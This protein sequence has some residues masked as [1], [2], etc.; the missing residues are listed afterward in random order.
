MIYVSD[1]GEVPDRPRSN[2]FRTWRLVDPTMVISNMSAARA[3]DHKGVSR[4]SGVWSLTV[5]LGL[6]YRPR[7]HARTVQHPVSGFVDLDLVPSGSR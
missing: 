6:C 2:I 5:A 1:G 7:H 3:R 4:V